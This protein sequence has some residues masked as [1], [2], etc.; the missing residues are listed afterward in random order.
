MPSEPVEHLYF[1]LHRIRSGPD[2]QEGF[3]SSDPLIYGTEFDNSKGINI[4][5]KENGGD[6]I[7][8]V[9]NVRKEFYPMVKDLEDIV[10]QLVD[11]ID[12]EDRGL[13]AQGTSPK[14][15]WFLLLR[16]ISKSTN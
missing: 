14:F 16:Q 3:L 6:D 2:N 7:D 15:L 9:A 5:L 4:A 8:L 11:N 10:H 12:E 1:I 13:L